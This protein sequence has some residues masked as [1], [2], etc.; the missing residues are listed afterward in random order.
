MDKKVTSSERVSGRAWYVV[1]TFSGYEKKV[2]A[3]L[4]SK[5][6]AQGLE[7][8][9]FDVIVPMRDES[10][11]KDGRRRIVKKKVFPGYVLVD[12]IVDN[13]SWF[14]VRN[15]QGVTGF[16]GSEKDPIPLSEEEAQ[17]IL[18]ELIEG[19]VVDDTLG[20]NVNDN[21]RIIDG[22]FENRLATI[23]SIDAEKQRLKVLVEDMPVDLDVSQVEK[24]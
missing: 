1:H 17:R 4:E 13:N 15:T 3:T 9:I 22:I 23:K 5:I 16:V 10:E 14:V 11:F 20:F 24:L 7:N 2:K 19:R 6:A 8:V 18:T 12:M 21:V